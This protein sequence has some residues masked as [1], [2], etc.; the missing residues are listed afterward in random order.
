[1][2][3]LFS[4]SSTAANFWLHHTA[5]KVYIHLYFGDKF[6]KEVRF[7]TAF[8]KFVT[9]LQLEEHISNVSSLLCMWY[10]TGCMI[11]LKW[12]IHQKIDDD[13]TK[14]VINLDC[15]VEVGLGFAMA[16]LLIY[17]PFKISL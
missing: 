5:R 10:A 7:S 17:S 16:M 8:Y 3:H 1:M 13:V 2:T 9:V 14:E 12:L 15:S 11:I 6:R 4:F